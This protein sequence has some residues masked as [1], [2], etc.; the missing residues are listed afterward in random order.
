MISLILRS[1]LLVK[2]LLEL[3]NLALKIFEQTL[4]LGATEFCNT[5][6]LIWL[7]VENEGVG[8]FAWHHIGAI[9]SL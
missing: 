4:G 3:T 2:L 9:L 8:R 5:S 7:V 6:N 1:L